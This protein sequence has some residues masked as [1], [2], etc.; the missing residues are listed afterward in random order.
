MK[1]ILVLISVLILSVSLFSQ[2]KD[3][4]SISKINIE[5]VVIT[6]T[7]TKRKVDDVPMRIDI[8]DNKRIE[9]FPVS[10]ID[11]ILK[12]TSNVYVNRSWGIYSKNSAVTMRGLESS[13][14][15]LV[16]VDGVPKNRI[17]GGSVNWHNIN[18]DIIEK[19]EII[20][21]PAS[22]LYGNN[23]MGGVINI[24]TKTPTEKFSGSVSGFAGRYNTF[25][26]SL[27][28]SG[29]EVKSG[30]GLFWNINGYYRKGDGYY[31]TVPEYLDETAAK[32]YLNEHGGG[33][34]IGYSINEN[35]RVEIVCDL[36]DEIRGAGKKIFIADGS[37]ES[38]ITDQVRAKYTGRI[39]SVDIN[40]VVYHSREDYYKQNESRNENN[41]YRLLDSYN[42]KNDQGFWVTG[43]QK[44][45][46]S[47][48]ITVGVELKTGDLNGS[49]IYRTSTDEIYFRS[50]MDILGIFIQ[51]ELGLFHDNIKLVAGIRND[52]VKFHDGYQ[53]IENP[54]KITGFS[55]GFTENFKSKNWID[56][57]PKLA[58][59]YSISE[60]SKAYVSASSGFMPPDLKDLGQTGKINKGFR[61]ANPDLD[62]ETLTNYEIGY[63]SELCKN[64]KFNTSIYYSI[65]N[66][67]MYMIGTGDSIDT[68]GSSLKPVLR[69]ENVG[70]VAIKGFE[71]N[72]NY[73][74]N[75]MIFFNAS[76]SYNNSKI[77]EFETSELNPD[78]DLTGKDLSEVSP[79]LFYAGID[80]KCKMF[81]LNI[82][83]NYVDEQWFDE[84]NTIL[85]D[86]Y[87]ILN[88]RISRVFKNHYRI[89]GDIQNILDNEFIDRKGNL[90]PGRFFTVG[91]KYII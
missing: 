16:I 33:A 91:F 44:I 5:E 17:G 24:I 2:E 72:F 1:E 56:V 21:G 40:A 41:E 11:D 79:N 8:I 68:G 7:R 12:S 38:I 80:Y 13:S 62:P 10:N 14:R 49:E 61:L 50:K 78:K 23:A 89:Y 81:N 15:V 9:N 60:K 32:T 37:Y 90:S 51:D 22:S 35:N 45:L 42:I 47:N 67:F 30:K 25:G 64:L 19:I 83:C 48:D 20:K 69:P 82:N 70:K 74:I 77:I 26:G 46:K 84:E 63:S 86:D 34:M 59:Q 52:M 36:Y 57:S 75:N 31:F 55:E 27:N 88:M 18:P 39:S 66:N 54:T 76:Y 71:V 58:F 73:H 85:I 28:L 53:N 87:F 29:S 3:T 4:I 6:A 43:T 65:G